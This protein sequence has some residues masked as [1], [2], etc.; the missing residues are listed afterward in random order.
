MLKYK[1][2]SLIYLLIINVK[3]DYI[4]FYGFNISDS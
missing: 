1:T 2:Y 3:A 4:N